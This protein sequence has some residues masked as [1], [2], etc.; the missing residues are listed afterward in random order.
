LL[1]VDDAVAGV[2]KWF[3]IYFARGNTRLVI[4]EIANANFYPTI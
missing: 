3:R 1:K 4:K 2:M